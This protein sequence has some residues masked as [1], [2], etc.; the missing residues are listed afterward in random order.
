MDRHMSSA[1]PSGMVRSFQEVSSARR[2]FPIMIPQKYLNVAFYKFADL[3]EPAALRQ[4]LRQE[5]RDSQLRGT[6]LLSAEGI[7]GFLAGPEPLLRRLMDR[8]RRIPGLS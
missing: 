5:L 4:E 1:T 6:I 3:P 8:L 2:G 7:N